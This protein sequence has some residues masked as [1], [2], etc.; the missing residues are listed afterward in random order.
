MFSENRSRT[1]VKAGRKTA[2]KS[3]LPVGAVI[4]FVAMMA[5]GGLFGCSKSGS[6]ELP[7]VPETELT[8]WIKQKAV[9]SNGDFT[10]LSPADQQKLQRETRNEGPQTLKMLLPKK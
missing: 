5:T 3:A 4:G 2:L 6:D 1:R 9:E 8:K 7:P 10:K